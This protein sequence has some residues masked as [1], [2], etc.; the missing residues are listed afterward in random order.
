[1]STISALQSPAC[2]NLPVGHKRRYRH[3]VGP[4]ADA[5]ELWRL[6]QVFKVLGQR[7]FH[8]KHV[9]EHWSHSRLEH[10]KGVRADRTLWVERVRYEEAG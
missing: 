10:N 3:E 6:S 1:M 2:R 9:L 7:V 4:Y 8:G 5:L